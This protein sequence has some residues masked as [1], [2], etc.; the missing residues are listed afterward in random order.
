MTN[1][2]ATGDRIIMWGGE[3]R[4]EFPFALLSGV[5]VVVTSGQLSSDVGEL[6]F[7]DR[8]R[9]L[10]CVDP[11]RCT[12]TAFPPGGFTQ[13]VGELLLQLAD[14]LGLSSAAF[15]RIGKIGLHRRLARSNS[16]G[17]CNIPRS[18]GQDRGV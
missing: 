17:R 15:Q 14:P 2:A 16:T 18:L 6:L 8:D 1:L 4:H 7:Q 3:I 13:R 9:L 5:Q 10:E 11:V 12:E